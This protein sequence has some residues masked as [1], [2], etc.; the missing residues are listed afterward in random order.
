MVAQIALVREFLNDQ[1]APSIKD[2]D[3]KWGHRFKEFY[4]SQLAVKMLC[5]AVSEGRKTGR[6]T[7]QNDLRPSEGVARGDI[8]T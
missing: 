1:N 5:A 2:I 7:G 8:S 4:D 3:A 6:K